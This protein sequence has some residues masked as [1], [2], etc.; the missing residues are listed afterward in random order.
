[1]N[2]PFSSK[3][4]FSAPTA[5]LVPFAGLYHRDD[6]D[7]RNAE[8]H[9]SL[10]C[11]LPGALRS[12]T[13]A[14][15]SVGVMFIFQF[16][17]M[18]F[19]LAILFILLDPYPSYTRIGRLRLRCARCLSRVVPIVKSVFFPVYLSSAA[20]T[21]GSAFPSRNSKDAPPPVEMWV[22]L[23][24]K[25]SWFT[26]A[27]ESPPPMMVVASVSARALATAMVPGCQGRVLEYAH[28]PVPYYGLRILYSLAVDLACLRSDVHAF[29][30]CGN[31]IC[32]NVLH[33]N[34]CVDGV[35]ECGT[36]QWYPPEGAASCPAFL[37]FPSFPYSSPA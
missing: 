32:G 8:H 18:I 9:V 7:G 24:P 10:F 29:F 26:A 16:P 28:G 1:M 21:P 4:I 17:A 37:P 13:R 34:R 30:I 2:A 3:Y 23:S 11:L 35:W 12:S 6:I 5:I 27:A 36:P 14:T 20:T 15:A 22:I 33:I 25:P 31:G 19:L